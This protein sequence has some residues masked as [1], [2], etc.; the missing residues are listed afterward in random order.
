MRNPFASIDF[1]H[2]VFER[3]V[4]TDAKPAGFLTAQFGRFSGLFRTF[5]DGPVGN[6]ML[7]LTFD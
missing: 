5:G 2:L 3:D 1:V 6:A 4:T 7:T